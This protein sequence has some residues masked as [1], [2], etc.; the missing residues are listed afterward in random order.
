MTRMLLDN[1]YSKEEIMEALNIKQVTF[2]KNLR[3]ILFAGF[4]YI[5]ENRKY[6][7]KEKG[8]EE[9][10]YP[11]PAHWAQF[12]SGPAQWLSRAGEEG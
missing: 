4:K 1:F 11:Y 10:L 2:F 7:I 3:L 12:S 9:G 8:K 5:K 6:N